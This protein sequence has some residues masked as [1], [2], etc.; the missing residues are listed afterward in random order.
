MCPQPSACPSR[1]GYA[2]SVRGL[3]ACFT[4]AACG[5][6]RG[7]FVRGAGCRWIFP[8]KNFLV[9]AGGAAPRHGKRK[10]EGQKGGGAA[11]PR[12]RPRALRLSLRDVFGPVLARFLRKLYR[13]WRREIKRGRALSTRPQLKLYMVSSPKIAGVCIWLYRLFC[14][15]YWG[16]HVLVIIKGA[17]FRFCFRPLYGN[18]SGWY[19]YTLPGFY[20]FSYNNWLF[21]V[22][23]AAV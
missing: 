20:P 17:V 15:F 11:A 14:G 7:Y 12:P 13:A 16:S 22:A 19:C 6:V 2:F 9:C 10:C 23:A 1:I 3:R 21:K 4:S 8:R 5:Y 18:G